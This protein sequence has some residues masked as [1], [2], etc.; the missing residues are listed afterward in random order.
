MCVPSAKTGKSAAEGRCTAQQQ[1]GERDRWWKAAMQKRTLLGKGITSH[2]GIGIAAISRESKRFR[3]RRL[4]PLEIGDE[5]PL[6]LLHRN[7][8]YDPRFL[9]VQSTVEGSNFTQAPGDLGKINL[10]CRLH[11]PA[12]PEVK[13]S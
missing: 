7:I 12:S 3:V 6:R 8:R 2:R 1:P 4:H 10:F 11:R 5:C 9:T 13:P